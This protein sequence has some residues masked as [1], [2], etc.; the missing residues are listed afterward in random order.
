MVEIRSAFPISDS[1]RAA[2]VS[3]MEKRTGKKMAVRTEVDARLLGGVIVKVGNKVLDDSV[4]TK[5]GN[6]KKELMK[7]QSI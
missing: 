1:Q 5:I 3:R 7:T 6:F 4:R 2:V